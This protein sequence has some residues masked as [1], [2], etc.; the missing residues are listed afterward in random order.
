MNFD[1]ITFFFFKDKIIGL[2]FGL[3]LNIFVSTQVDR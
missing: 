2:L 3:L 1:I